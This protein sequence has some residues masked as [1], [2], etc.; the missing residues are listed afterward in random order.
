MDADDLALAERPRVGPGDTALR[1]RPAPAK[2]ASIPAPSPAPIPA[3]PGPRDY[4]LI[5]PCRDEALL[6]R[7]TLDSVIA[8]SI[9][10]SLWVIVD[11]GSRDAS[12]AILAEYAA[13]HH[14]I[15]IVTRLD[16][17]QRAVGP[18]VIEA[19]YAGCAT[20]ELDR[21]RFLCKLDLDLVLPPRY[22]ERLMGRME[23]DPLLA[24]CSGKAYIRVGDQLV[25]E[26]HG[27]EQSIG[28]SK[29][30][31]MSCFQALGGFSRDVMWDG[32][33]GHRCRMRGWRAMSVDDPELRF[34]H[35]RPMGTSQTGVLAG[36][37]RHGYGQYHMGTSFLYM[38]ANAVNRL[39]ERPYVLGSLAMLWGW[40]SSA[41]RGAP[42]YEEPG[43]RP[44]LRRWQ[45][46]AL[47]K[48]KRRALKEFHG[49]PIVSP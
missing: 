29:F 44:F 8:Q 16:R 28:A 1:K 48:G 24:T 33:D 13:R 31:R 46:L 11:D 20:V 14:W 34:I 38:L 7:Q 3:P 35:L 41:W 40:I 47:L 49:E 5:S 37:V 22:F 2:P 45:W 26:R 21:Y 17:G 23:A 39:N 43:F 36:R 42:R 27:D 18:G 10:P 30:Y 4:V 19:F 6:M 32:I 12:P 25:H 15:R 9:R